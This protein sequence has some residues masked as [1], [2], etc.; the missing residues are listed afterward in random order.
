MARRTFEIAFELAGRISSSFGSM[1]ASASERLQQLNRQVSSLKADI[2]ELEKAQKAGK[3]SADEYANSY[4][5]LTAQLTKAERAQQRLA[6][7]VS[8]QKRVD[9]FRGRMQDYLFGAAGM[10]A[11]VGAPVYAAMQFES[12]MADVRKV[13]DFEAPQQF[14]QMQKDILN[15]SKRIPMA[16]EGLAQI[17]AA[18]GQAGIAREELIGFA[19]AA[20]K[21]GVAFD[22]TAEEAGQTMAQWRSAFKMNQKQVQVLAD[23][24]N[25]LGNTTAAS[26]P[27]ISDV[28]RRIGPLGE[29]GG[30]AAGQ[31]AALGATMV[32]AGVAEEVAATGIKNLIL[33]LVAGESATKSQAEAFKALGLDA[34]QMAKMMQK[35]AQGA[36]LTVLRALR[37][38]P[39]HKRAAVLADLFG[40]ES[41]G[42]ISPLLT[43]LEALEENFKKVADAAQYAGSMEKEFE[44]RSKTTQN[45]LQ[46]LRNRATELG[47]T[48][49]SIL[50]PHI[51]D[52]VQ[53]LSR[54]VER[55]STFAEK[56][57]ALARGLTIGAAA[58]FGLG[59]AFIAL[60]YVVSSII[61]PI[62]GFYT[63]ARKI[64]L[65][66]KLASIPTK[67]WAAAQWLLNAA[68]R[69]GQGLLSVGRLALYHA[70][71]LA[72]AVATKAWAAAQWLLN[73]ALSAN[74]I[75]L[76]VIAV[77]GLAAGLL[78]LY[79][80]S[81]K[82]RTAVD[83]FWKGLKSGA[84]AAI[85]FVIN[86]INA[87][88]DKIN[89]FIDLLNKIKIP[90]WVPIIGGK[91]LSI[92]KIER[93]SRISTGEKIPGH[94]EGGIFSR[95]HL[96]L[97]AEAG[98]E[99][100]IPLDGSPRSLG[101]LARAGELLGVRPV[102]G[103]NI[104]YAPVYNIYGGSN[105]EAQVRRAAKA[106]EDDF[107]ARFRAYVRQE[108]RLSYA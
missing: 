12:A 22:I 33:G 97:V 4:A 94:A 54:V 59:A 91:G 99:A 38:L 72:V 36:I 3:I 68:M 69:A 23:Q 60:G 26:A 16:A 39:E 42:A 74:P 34:V 56:H 15:L 66:S 55:V 1:F 5:R 40:K 57:P 14:Q 45:S 62:V 58:A 73:V 52:L 6:K 67:A 46:L 89:I 88:I 44:E 37:K 92:P 64:E 18:G 81:E 78:I 80:R 93:I 83:A 43:N 53:S 84:V 41:I 48:V 50:L 35:D 19:E 28:V 49:G 30:A 98:P 90:D 86:K 108:R 2:K 76:V 104:T 107:A 70:K 51:N 29:V 32:S 61:S 25:Y 102:G 24:I 8:L 31:I 20:A 96:A 85:N 63:W 103:A 17:V 87:L 10:A 11:T 21:M 75:G 106:A 82:V 95:P 47:I 27:K 105:V 71:S 7:A 100:V 65:T 101:L 77:A 79:H 9:E 13:V